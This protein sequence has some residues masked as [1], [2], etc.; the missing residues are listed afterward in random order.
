MGRLFMRIVGMWG[1]ALAFCGLCTP[2]RAEPL[3]TAGIGLASCAKL[4]Q[5][6]SPDQG[7]NNM[8]NALLYYWTQG[9]MS[10]AN[11]HLLEEDSQ[12]VDLNAIDEKLVIATVYGF[13]K[14]NPD[15]KPISAIDGLIRGAK[16]IEAADWKSGT[17]KWNE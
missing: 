17:L 13:C 10:A 11:M 1:L 4:V 12:H 9:Y 14:D 7:L 3:T 2:A 16:K 6:M 15:K 5:D 8:P